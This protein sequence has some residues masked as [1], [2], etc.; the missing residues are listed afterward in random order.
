MERHIEGA[1]QPSRGLHTAKARV[2]DFARHD[3]GTRRNA[4]E[5]WMLDVVASNDARDMGTV[6]TI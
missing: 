1:D 4:V 5:L 6:S 3:L 2:A